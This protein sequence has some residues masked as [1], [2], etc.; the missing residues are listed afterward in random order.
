VDNLL[1]RVRLALA[2]SYEIHS[3]VGRGGMA[4]VYLATDLRHDRTVA[5]K[6]LPPD[7]ASAVGH[8]R[9][10]HEIQVSAG[11]S[12]PYILPL[13]DSGQTDGLLY[14]VM[15][16]VDGENLSERL[17]REAQLPIEDA[18]RIADEMAEALGHAHAL[19]VIHRDVKP[20]NILLTETHAA[21]ADFGIA[22]AID[23][24][25]ERLTGTGLS[26]GTPAYMSPQQGLADERIDGASDQYSL[27]CVI[28]EMLAGGPPFTAS[29]PDAVLRRHVM[30]PIPAIRTVRPSVPAAVEAA[31]TR[32]LSKS[33]DSRFPSME[34]F[35]S[36]LRASAPETSV[37]GPSPGRRAALVV[38]GGV[39]LAAAAFGLSTLVSGGSTMRPAAA[40]S[41]LALL[42]C[43][44]A[45]ANDSI[46][47]WYV[48]RQVHVSLGGFPTIG[49]TQYA[50]S[51]AWARD[52]ALGGLSMSDSV[53]ADGREQLLTS[54]LGTCRLEP[55][56]DDSIVV[57]YQLYPED[58]LFTSESVRLARMTESSVDDAP[59]VLA[60]VG[61]LCEGSTSCG[62][63]FR[64]TE[65]PDA[66]SY[67][68]EADRYFLQDRFAEAEELFGRA[69]DMD[70]EFALARWRQAEASR[71]QAI[72]S[73]EHID[74]RRLFNEQADRLGTRDSLLLSALVEPPGPLAFEKFETV[75]ERL[76]GDAYAMLLY[77]DELLHRGPLWGITLDSVESVLKA[78]TELNPGFAPAWDHLA[79]VRIRLGMEGE[80]AD[81]VRR[82]DELASPVSATNPLPMDVIWG[83]GWLERFDPDSAD[84]NR[85]VLETD[86]DLLAVAARLVRYGDLPRAQLELGTALMQH[87]DTR[88]GDRYWHSGLNAMGLAHASLGQPDAAQEAFLD[89]GALTLAAALFADQW[90]IVPVALGLEGFSEAAAMQAVHRLAEV[91]TDNS[92]VALDRARAAWTLA[93]FSPEAGFERWQFLVA[94]LPDSAEQIEPLV[95]HLEAVALSRDRRWQDALE[96]SRALIAYDSVGSTERPFARAAIYLTR[97]RWF[98]AAGRRGRRG[99]RFS[100]TPADR[101]SR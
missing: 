5:I 11:L 78:A 88:S 36:A 72:P 42:P 12:H 45:D 20:S 61:L 6:V 4:V 31:L 58:G 97:G 22:F 26:V 8:E 82:L 30:D 85:V 62:S 74:I 100:C 27:A 46:L 67:Y 89:A 56:S 52:R 40:M 55:V 99:I 63:S 80:A 23:R 59:L 87:P 9:F 17:A 51:V 41:R 77:G 34:A 60:L 70:P 92:E 39:V 7:L 37:V 71:W 50:Q 81:A 57:H 35:A 65:N 44:A 84:S 47:G 101:S 75:L 29:T 79:Q 95:Q 21:L 38:G 24:G 83:H 33:P 10:L 73:P 94:S 1:Q 53:A 91:A 76:P 93:L 69:A 18:L 48:A 49:V 43:Q 96:A 3:E 32:A 25:D 64:P 14:Y 90:A 15:P 86:K 66:M 54:T 28:Y 19:G 13:L 16:F 98:E 2:D 68:L